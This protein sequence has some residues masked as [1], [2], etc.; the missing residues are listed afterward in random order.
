MGSPALKM[1]A[2]DSSETLVTNCQIIWITSQKTI[3]FID[4]DV[5]CKYFYS[6][7]IKS[8]FL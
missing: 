2:A 6:D 8:L 3:M 4:K 1:K 5:T 7:F